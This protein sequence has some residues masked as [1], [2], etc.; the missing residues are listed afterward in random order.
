VTAAH[1]LG[2]AGGVEPVLDPPKVAHVLESW[3]MFPRTSPRDTVK[4]VGPHARTPSIKSEVWTDLVI[5]DIAPMSVVALPSIPLSL[6]AEPIAIGARVFLIACPYEQEDCT[7]NVYPAKVV[8][9]DHDR[10]KYTFESPVSLSGMSGAPVLD[11]N[12]LV[13]GVMTVWF[14]PKREGELYLEGGGQDAATL[15]R[16]LEA[17]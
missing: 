4:V 13:A 9:R 6:R 11:E 3:R 17:D 10:F 5:L 1:L 2:P 16:I 7:Q 8:A 14:E 12:G 15:Y